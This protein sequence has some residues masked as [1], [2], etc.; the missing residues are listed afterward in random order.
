MLLKVFLKFENTICYISNM[1][2]LP[3]S[4]LFNSSLEKKLLKTCQATPRY[5]EYLLKYIFGSSL[6][7]KGL[8]VN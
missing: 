7:F 8:C 6:F 4:P 3:Y 1:W 5:I 2:T